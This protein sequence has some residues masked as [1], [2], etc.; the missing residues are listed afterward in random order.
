MGIFI[1]RRIAWKLIKS[2]LWLTIGP[3]AF[4]SLVSDVIQIFDFTNKNF[5]TMANLIKIGAEALFVIYLMCPMCPK[6]SADLA[7]YAG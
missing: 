7:A 6:S 2:K 5:G 1:K 4:I 3:L